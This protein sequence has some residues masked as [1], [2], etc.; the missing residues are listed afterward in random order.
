[1]KQYYWSLVI[2]TEWVQ[3]SIWTIEKEDGDAAGKGA[4]SV[5]FVSEPIAYGG[6]ADLVSATDSALSS[7][8]RQLPE[9]AEEPSKTVF[10]VNPSWVEGG[11]IVRA[12][13]DD[14]RLLCSKLSLNPVGF[15]VLPEAIAHFATQEEGAPLSG[16]IVGVG[17]A[18]LDVS[19]FRLGNLVGTVNV[20]RSNSISDDLVEGLT[21]FGP[22]DPF[23]S[24]FLLYD[25]RLANLEEAK[26]ELIKYDWMKIEK[27]KFLHTPQVDVVTP[28]D[29]MI[30]VSFAGAFE[31]A[32]V[33]DV[34]FAKKENV[35]NVTPVDENMGKQSLGSGEEVL[36][37]ADEMGF[38]I[39]RDVSLETHETRTARTLPFLRKP[40]VFNGKKFSFP[41]LS[42]G[43]RFQRVNGDTKLALIIIGVLSLF[44]VL[45]AA[46]WFL[47]KSTVAITVVPKK[48]EFKKKLDLKTLPSRTIN[49]SVSGDKTRSSSGTKTIGQAAKGQ[50]D[51]ENGTASEISVPANTQ[52]VTTSGLKFTTDTSLTVPAAASPHSPG[53]AGA[54]VTAAGYGSDY[55]LAKGETFQVGTYSKLEVDAIATSDFSG[56][57]SQEVVAVSKDDLKSLLD[58]LTND[59]IE[60]GKSEMVSKVEED[61]VLVE[62]TLIA[63]PSSKL[64]D[65]SAGDEASSVKLTEKVNVTATVVSKA[66]LL[67]MARSAAPPIPSGYDFNDDSV[68]FSFDKTDI[69]FT[70]NLVPKIDKADLAKKIAGFRPVAVRGILASLPGFQSA[71]I[72]TTPTLPG[73]LGTLPHL[74]RNIKIEIVTE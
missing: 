37:E 39:G 59:L 30:A 21:R 53:L 51:V 62:N 74:P 4:T 56:G 45:T 54:A 14:I 23:P 6:E 3:A 43:S 50:V 41:L 11:Q 70:I 46:W 69:K 35:N 68:L 12:H 29:K 17:E 2:D 52:I 38:G 55:N 58:S 72:N 25:S 34:I 67:E 42:F 61:E 32:G 47:P 24:R 36:V 31:M 60:K 20:S 57:S 10:G 44:L 9:D 13:L 1:M 63:T 40:S 26:Q 22:G 18:A 64:F 65:H 49:T 8:A 71:E 27:L 66:T 16:V 19:V 15:V 73:F 5:K 33:K 28:R 7:I 48:L